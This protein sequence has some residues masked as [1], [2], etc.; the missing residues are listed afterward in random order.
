MAAHPSPTRSLDWRF[1][2]LGV[3][4]AVNV[5]G[6][7]IVV[8]VFL[9]GG[10]GADWFI[11]SEAGERVVSGGLYDAEPRGYNYIYS[12]L[13]AYAWIAPMPLWAWLAVHFLAI[14]DSAPLSRHPDVGQ[15]PVLARPLQRRRDGVP[16][17]GSLACA[18]WEPY[19]GRSL[20]RPVP[21]GTSAS[22]PAVRAVATLE[23]TG[24]AATFRGAG[25][26]VR[27][28][29]PRVR[30]GT[31]WVTALL[32]GPGYTG[33]DRDFGPTRIIGYAWL[34]VGIPLGGV[35]HVPGSGSDG[36]VWP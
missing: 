14:A 20:L 10:V 16:V 13:L 8:V 11:F 19:R 2:G 22:I 7:A 3:L 36:A 30:M 4:G 5:V 31:E 23:A 12:P 18:A 24:V 6:L 25:R 17:R 29:S 34:I 33:V 1:L 15:L 9:R 28:R 35:A 27:R 21:A 26:C 32:S